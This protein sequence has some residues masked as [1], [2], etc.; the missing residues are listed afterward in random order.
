MNPTFKIGSSLFRVKMV[1]LP[2]NHFFEIGQFSKINGKIKFM[3]E[4][5]W[6]QCT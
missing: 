1:F 2:F 6:I 4:H 5:G 3:V